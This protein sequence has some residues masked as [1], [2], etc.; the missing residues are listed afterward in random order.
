MIRRTT[1]CSDRRLTHH[2]LCLSSGQ[3]GW[4]TSRSPPVV[5][6]AGAWLALDRTD[7]RSDIGP[8]ID[9]TTDCGSIQARGLIAIQQS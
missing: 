9:V 6:A 5:A 3:A 2:I 4:S 7:R 1:G 8:V